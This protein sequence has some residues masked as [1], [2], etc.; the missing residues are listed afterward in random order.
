[1]VKKKKKSKAKKRKPPSPTDKM[2]Q[3]AGIAA[4]DYVK[5][6]MVVGLGTGSTVEHTIR[7]ISRRNLDIIGIPTSKQTER[8]ARRLKI[9][10]AKP[11]DYAHA[12]I[13]IDGADE[14]D[15]KLNL[16]KGGGGALTREKIVAA[17]SDRMI[18]VVDKGKLVHN[19]GSFPVAV[20]VMRLAKRSVKRTLEKMGASV[21]ERKGKTDNGNTILDARFGAIPD[22]AGLEKR[23]N[24]IPG[25][26]ENGIFPMRFVNYVLVGEEK[27]VKRL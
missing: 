20:E 16:I 13:D 5:S 15:S 26:I 17:M 8:L 9:R 14:V 27:G 11:N 23:I 22:P 1:M 24:N 19:L 2:K 25:V 21:T 10:L 18:V 4:A 7:E 12:D 3:K 6:G